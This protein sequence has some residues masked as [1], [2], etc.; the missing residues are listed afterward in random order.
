MLD[1]D[2]ADLYQVETGA[3]NRAVKR[4]IQRFPEGFMFQLSSEEAENLKC[5]IGISS[6]GGRRR[7]EPRAFTE[8]GVAMLSSVLRS[9]GAI[10]VNIIIMNTF[11]NLREIVS[12][13]EKLLQKIEVL[14]Q[15]YE[16]HDK[17]LK[18]VFQVIRGLID[19]PVKP[20]RPIGIKP[21]RE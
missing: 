19:F 20:K 15:K 21:R 9:E 5:Q 11:V 3:L 12:G 1:S 16:G 7:S 17:Q 13:N 2:L 10:Q 8:R 4:N 14:E 18:Q 6:W